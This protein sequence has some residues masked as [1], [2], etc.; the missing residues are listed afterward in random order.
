MKDEFGLLLVASLIA[1][2]HTH[3]AELDRVKGTFVWGQ[4]SCATHRRLRSPSMIFS[5]NKREQDGYEQP[6]HWLPAEI[7]E[8]NILLFLWI[9]SGAT[10]WGAK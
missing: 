3:K 6:H 5:V 1:E 10:V 7:S 8:S 4:V 2:G 9:A